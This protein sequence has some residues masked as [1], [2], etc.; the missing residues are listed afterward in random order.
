MKKYC[1][2]LPELFVDPESKF[3]YLIYRC[4]DELRAEW[5]H[6]YLSPVGV[7]KNLDNIQVEIWTLIFWNKV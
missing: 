4:C 3:N 2:F 5:L 1:L 6:P 7:V